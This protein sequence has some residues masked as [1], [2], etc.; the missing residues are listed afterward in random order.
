MNR[1]IVS[2]H[3]TTCTITASVNSVVARAVAVKDVWYWFNPA[4]TIKEAVVD[5]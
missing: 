4:Q 1:V 5:E 3:T 2:P